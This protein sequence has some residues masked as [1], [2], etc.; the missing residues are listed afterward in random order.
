MPSISLPSGLPTAMLMPTMTATTSLLRRGSR[1][2]PIPL[3]PTSPRTLQRL[4]TPRLLP[5]SRM[6][7]TTLSLLLCKSCRLSAGSSFLPSSN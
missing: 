3:L 1:T 5:K 6:P 4:R 7:R 2:L